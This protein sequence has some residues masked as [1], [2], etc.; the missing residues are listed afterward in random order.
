MKKLSNKDEACLQ[1]AMD[2]LSRL[3]AN[4]HD[5]RTIMHA[6]LDLN[7]IIAELPFSMPL[8]MD[9][10][11]YQDK[12]EY[13]TEIKGSLEDRCAQLITCLLTFCGHYN[14]DIGTYLIKR[15]RYDLGE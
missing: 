5:K 14:I 12:K 1:V 6:T 3:L 13:N 10:N 15:S 4:K 11:A 9:P 8:G 7:R 2:N